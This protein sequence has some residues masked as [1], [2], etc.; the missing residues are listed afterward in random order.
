[1]YTHLS[2][3]EKVI[4]LRQPETLQKYFWIQSST[5]TA[6][7]ISQYIDFEYA[8]IVKKFHFSWFKT[9]KKFQYL[10]STA[11]ESYRAF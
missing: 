1:M 2:Y 11:V 3:F 7:L 6:D 9:W 5:F 4:K 10:E 8:F